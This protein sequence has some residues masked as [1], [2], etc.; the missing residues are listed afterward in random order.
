MPH[1]GMV[2]EREHDAHLLAR[3]AFQ[4]KG[5]IQEA[6]RARVIDWFEKFFADGSSIETDTEI[7]AAFKEGEQNLELSAI[8][9][10]WDLVTGEATG[11]EYPWRY[12]FLMRRTR[13]YDFLDSRQGKEAPMTVVAE[14]DAE[15][16][17]WLVLY[18]ERR[19]QQVP[20]EGEDR[21]AG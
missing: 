7:E 19:H 16:G 20:F 10:A 11:F 3:R 17:R 5:K 9:C 6:A 4:L 21:R 8:R 14:V 18:L 12:K 13:V 15:E 2:G 1:D